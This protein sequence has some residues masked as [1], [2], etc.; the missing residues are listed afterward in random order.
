MSP[1]SS[2]ILLHSADV[3][4]F[5]QAAVATVLLYN[6]RATASGYGSDLGSLRSGQSSKAAARPSAPPST[7]SHARAASS[8][9]ECSPLTASVTINVKA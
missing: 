5:Q 8:A 7:V 6:G 9:M 2:V 4:D 1:I 3:F